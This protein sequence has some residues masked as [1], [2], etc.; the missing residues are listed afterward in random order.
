MHPSWG[1]R[2]LGLEGLRGIAAMLVVVHHTVGH[3]SSR[4]GSRSLWL[5][6]EVAAQGLTLFFVLSGFLLYR[7]FLTALVTGGEAPSIRRYL[8]N[9]GLRI[10]PAY[11]VVLL[12]ASYVFGVA[13]SRSVVV[14]GPTAVG[15][16]TDPVTL[17]ANLLLVQTYLPST[18]LTGL[19]VAWSLTAELAF[20]VILPGLFVGA[21]FLVRRHVPRLVAA[22]L[23]VVLMLAVGIT[24][25]ALI[26]AAKAGLDGRAATI[27]SWGNTWTAVLDR[28]V[29]SQAHLFG[30]GMAAALVIVYLQ[31]RGV[32]RSPRWVVSALVALVLLCIVVALRLHDAAQT[33]LLG[34]ASAVLVVAVTLPPATQGRPANALARALELL[35][36]RYVGLVSY[37]IYLWHVPVIQWI[38]QRGFYDDGSLAT[39]LVSVLIVSAATLALAS[40]TYFLV[41]KPALGLKTRTRD[42]PAPVRG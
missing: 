15:P 2:L 9:R 13:Y 38:E 35:P 36:L 18:V 21:A 42:R 26:G 10:F 7:P 40:A 8:R 27:F 20:Y 22:A 17:V 39:S 6:A 12:L 33:N 31:S 41:E 30:Y 19:N 5:F 37:S 34:A 1:R 32:T 25:S 24:T 11:L 14:Y 28:S 4:D 16:I 23:P 29:V 3:L